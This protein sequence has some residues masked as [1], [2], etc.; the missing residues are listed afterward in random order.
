LTVGANSTATDIEPRGLTANSPP[1]TINGAPCVGTPVTIVT[2]PVFLIWILCG[3]EWL[4]TATLLK[5]IDV[6]LSLSLPPTGV[7]VA[8][9]VAVAVAD[10]VAV[11]VVV[12]VGEGEPVA[13]TVGV[14]VADGVGVGTIPS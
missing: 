2:V 7:G 14:A 9:G 4:P 13:V 1:F 6:G 5:W 10:A 11:A 3:G 12:V 8:E